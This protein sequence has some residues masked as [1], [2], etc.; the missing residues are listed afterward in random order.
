MTNNRKLTIPNESYELARLLM[1]TGDAV[2]KAEAV[3]RRN[4]MLIQQE[5]LCF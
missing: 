2:K 1:V 3:N 5:H 4:T